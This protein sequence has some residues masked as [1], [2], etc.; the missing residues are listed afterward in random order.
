VKLPERMLDRH[1]PVR[2]DGRERQ[3]AARENR[4]CWPKRR[5]QYINTNKIYR[6]NICK[7]YEYLYFRDRLLVPISTIRGNHVE[8]LGPSR[9]VKEGVAFYI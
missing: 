4:H 9:F 7:K 6:F 5:S 2:G 3:R 1:E 8:R